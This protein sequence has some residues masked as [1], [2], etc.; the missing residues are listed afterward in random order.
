[1]YDLLQ[2]NPASLFIT[3]FDF[4]TLDY[5]YVEGYRNKN[6]LNKHAFKVEDVVQCSDNANTNLHNIDDDFKYF[7]YLCSKFRHK[8]SVDSYIKS[9]FSRYHTI[10][11]DFT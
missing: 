11:T 3:G 8:I 7:H 9:L 10:L 5:Y 1:M 4:Y 2:C 6:V